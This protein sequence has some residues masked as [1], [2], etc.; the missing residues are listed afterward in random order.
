M[1]GNQTVP[2]YDSAEYRS[3]IFAELNELLNYRGLLR[4]YISPEH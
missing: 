3:P 1:N 4:Q 2:E